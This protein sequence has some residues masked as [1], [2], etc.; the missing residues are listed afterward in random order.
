LLNY[1]VASVR[2]TTFSTFSRLA[3]LLTG[4]VL[5]GLVLFG[6]SGCGG[7]GTIFPSSGEL[8]P[9][10]VSADCT[11][12]VG[13]NVNHNIDVQAKKKWTFLVY[14]N[15]ANDLE[16]FGIQ[17]MNQMEKAGSTG[18]VNIVVQYERIKGRY[19]S[20]NGD[21]GNTRRYYVTRDTS[22]SS[23]VIST[24]L[25]ESTADMGKVASLK[26]FTDWGVSTFPAEN[27]AIVLWDH[28]AGWRAQKV[29]TASTDIT[30]GLSYNDKTST[31][32]DT[33]ELPAGLQNANLRNGK[34][35]LAIIDC[36]LMQMAEVAYEIR[37]NA[38][39]IVG[40][41]ES[42]P[43]AG[44]P[45]DRFLTPL[46]LT[47]DMDA[48]AL[49]TR[50]VNETLDYYGKDSGTTQSMLDASRL[51]AIAPALDNLGTALWNARTTYSSQ[52]ATAREETENYGYGS[53]PQYKDM[54][55]YLRFLSTPTLSVTYVGDA[56]VQSA[57]SQ[58][59][60]AT[61]AAI[62][63][64]VNGSKHPRSNGLAL[65][66]PS[67]GDTGEFKRIDNVQAG[68][69]GQRYQALALAKDAPNWKQ[70]IQFGSP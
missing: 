65:F 61:Q 38:R 48:R 70:F 63:V 37:N 36:S 54:L 5:S 64:N 23:T 34:W 58:L 10:A 55:D 41:E 56:N 39:Y 45:Y 21:W 29:P 1:N 27:Y 66:I 47:P 4:L 68:G 43:G 20:S 15:G 30:R 16:P 3:P 52:L 59:K 50:I 13:W 24:L 28:G 26:E 8:T 44:Y 49:G 46:V 33:V 18:D 67:G 9:C 12:Q 42:P 31:H 40:S 60:N 11:R 53:Y 14:M 35:D 6:V 57:V 2:K 69:F 51:E 25:S 32:I 62:V 22:D 17:N 7:H 19:D